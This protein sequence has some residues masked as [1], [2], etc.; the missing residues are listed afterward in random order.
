MKTR[1]KSPRR[2]IR[3]GAAPVALKARGKT[4]QEL[5]R[6]RG[7]K[8]FDPQAFAGIVPPGEDM[9]AFVEEIYSART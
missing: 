6:E 2:R 3:K 1:L 7:A 8:P 5:A 4:I 9:G